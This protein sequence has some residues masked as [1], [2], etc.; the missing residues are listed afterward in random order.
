MAGRQAGRP[1][2]VEKKTEPTAFN[3]VGRSVDRSIDR[4]VVF[5]QC[6]SGPP[7]PRVC[8]VM[9]CRVAGRVVSVDVDI[10]VGIGVGVDVV[11]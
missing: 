11:W 8:H 5:S 2:V 1:V 3:P 10:G 6:G 9:P 4:R 7:A